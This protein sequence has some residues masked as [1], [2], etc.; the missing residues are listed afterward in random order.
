MVEV[1]S[2][3]VRV[4]CKFGKG[5]TSSELGAEQELESGRQLYFSSS[6]DKMKNTCKYCGTIDFKFKKIKDI[7]I[8]FKYDGSKTAITVAA[9]VDSKVLVNKTLS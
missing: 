1:P 3:S 4:V 9:S 8:E 2:P 6:C 7:C 5:S